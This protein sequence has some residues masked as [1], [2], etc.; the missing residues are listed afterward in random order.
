MIII[1]SCS[2]N[3]NILAMNDE[4][5]ERGLSTEVCDILV[6]NFDKDISELRSIYGHIR[7]T[8]YMSCIL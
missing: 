7:F 3:I 1:I 4:Y 6:T 8:N 2:R 5:V